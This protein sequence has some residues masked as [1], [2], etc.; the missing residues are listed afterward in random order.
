MKRGPNTCLCIATERAVCEDR[1][2]QT[3]Q[4][5]RVKTR[6]IDEA[7][8]KQRQITGSEEYNRERKSVKVNERET[9]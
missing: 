5:D 7:E 3:R 1:I 9:E 4:Q 2:G 6:V 8:E